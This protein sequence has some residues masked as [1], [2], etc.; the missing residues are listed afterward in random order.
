MKLCPKP[1]R[2]ILMSI[3][4]CLWIASCSSAPVA[5]TMMSSWGSVIELGQAEQSDAPGLWVTE[6]RLTA[7][8]V[9]ADE[10]GIHQD[11]RAIT[12]QGLAERVVLPLPP[13]NPYAQGLFP[14]EFDNLH[15]LWLDN[16][17]SG[18]LRLYSALITPRLDVARG[19]TLISNELTWRYVAL[20]NADGSLWIIS[21]GGTAFEPG[22]Y[23]RYVDSEGRPRFAANPQIVADADWP[24]ILRTNNGITYLFW[25]QRSTG[26]V[27]SA[28]LVDGQVENTKTIV[29]N[30]AL[31][32][33]DRLIDFGA[34]LDSTD[35]Y[36]IWNVIRANGSVEVWYSSG[37]LDAERWPPPK[38]LGIS[39]STAPFETGF[40]SGSS[41]SA[42]NGEGWISW[43]VPMRG[44]FDVLA[45]VAVLMNGRLGIIYFRSGEV[46]GVQE[47]V[48]VSRLLGLPRLLTDRDRFLYLAWSEP[49]D[50]GRT[51]MR[52]TT[53]RG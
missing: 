48:S 30:I 35:G 29:E 37:D 33:A 14:A 44:Q 8:W 52:L 20:S 24:A 46:R 38:R 28:T 53:S 6:S 47:I 26:Q 5:P 27:L 22:L 32:P 1:S 16:D 49:G 31:D 23:A 43:A 21:S 10:T 25:L 13:R 12:P 2:S 7:A 4:I 50:D 45:I 36:L 11:I 34:G 40:N 41:Q 19:P 9:G 39:V 15:L 3:V 51:H 17:G 42:G 18:N